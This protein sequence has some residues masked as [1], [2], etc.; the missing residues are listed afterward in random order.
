MHLLYA[1]FWTKVMFD[2]GLVNFDEPFST[3]R[4]HGMILAPD[5]RKM[6]KSWGNTI[7]PGEL[8][9]QGYGAD[10]IRLM[11]LF[12]GPW[13]QAAN[14][15]VEGMGGTFRFLQRFWT[16][17][18]EF[19]EAPAG[20]SDKDLQ[21]IAQTHKTIKKVS[22]D[23]EKLDFNTAIAAMM[24]LINEFYKIK[25]EQPIIQSDG[26][27]FALENLTQL[28]APFA[29]HIAEEVWHD[30][31]HEESVHVS[32]WPAWD[33]K[34]VVEDIITLA[35]QIN[36]KVRAEI[37]APA[38]ITKEAAIAAAKADEKI[39]ALIKD[40]TIKKEIYVPGRLVSLVVE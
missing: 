27:R 14:W 33:D 9:D 40:K 36:G 19:L 26:W 23:L 28:L 18:G 5:G 13:D 24:G 30:L 15:S 10:S 22:Q 1:R 6:S 7:E 32:A 35:V 4:N 34:L 17:V 21:I 25:A 2:D 31:G 3:L 20:S 16:L 29:P 38:D 12:I 8:I 39:A 37:V 11:E